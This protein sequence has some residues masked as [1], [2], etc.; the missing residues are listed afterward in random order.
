MSSVATVLMALMCLDASSMPR[1]HSIESVSSSYLASYLRKISHQLLLDFFSPGIG[2][3]NPQ[4]F[5]IKLSENFS[6]SN[7]VR[8]F[9]TYT[10][11][12]LY[13]W[14]TDQIRIS[15]CWLQLVTLFCW[16]SWVCRWHCSFGSLC[17][18]FKNDA[19]YLLSICQW[20]QPI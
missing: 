17:L 18:S 12:C 7:G 1:R 10:F 8:C 3:K 19:Q 6:V 14:I 16:S 13:W 20:L 4:F 5:G 2:I 15:S 9:I 11:H